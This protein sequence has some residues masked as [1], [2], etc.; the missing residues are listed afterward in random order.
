MMTA[1]I[2]YILMIIS[3]SGY[4]CIKYPKIKSKILILDMRVMNKQ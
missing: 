4:L 3:I 1:V 2:L